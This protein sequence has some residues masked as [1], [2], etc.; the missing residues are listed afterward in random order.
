MCPTAEAL[1]RSIR[2]A[3][4]SQGL[5]K[6]NN[7]RERGHRQL[8]DNQRAQIREICTEQNLQ[9]LISM[10]EAEEQ[11][12][13]QNRMQKDEVPEEDDELLC[14]GDQCDLKLSPVQRGHKIIELLAAI[15]I[16]RPKPQNTQRY[17]AY[18]ERP[19]QCANIRITETQDCVQ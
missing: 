7:Y 13:A 4:P 18:L 12:G 10:E 6:H 15:K 8:N 14:G 5:R 2:F 19:R 11:N 16:H 3:H 17:F 9:C 1:L